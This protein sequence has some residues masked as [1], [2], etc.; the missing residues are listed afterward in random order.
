VLRKMQYRDNVIIIEGHFPD[1]LVQIKGLEKPFVRFRFD[2]RGLISA[3]IIRTR[4]LIPEVI[5]RR[6]YIRS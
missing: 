3:N 1:S 5:E 4:I 6:F 2:R